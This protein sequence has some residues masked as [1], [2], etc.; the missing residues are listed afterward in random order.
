LGEPKELQKGLRIATIAALVSEAPG[1]T[2]CVTTLFF[3]FSVSVDLD[4]GWNAPTVPAMA[5]ANVKESFIVL[6]GEGA[7]EE[8]LLVEDQRP[9]LLFFIEDQVGR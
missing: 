3:E 2:G 9:F 8:W 7:E 4:E 5:R 6:E 1:R